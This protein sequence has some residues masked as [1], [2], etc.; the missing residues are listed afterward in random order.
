M[1]DTRYVGVQLSPV[2]G[3]VTPVGMLV[4]GGEMQLTT[5]WGGS[6]E[7]RLSERTSWLGDPPAQYSRTSSGAAPGAGVQV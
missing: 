4:G 6:V 1:L 2:A 5:A 7:L 3:Q